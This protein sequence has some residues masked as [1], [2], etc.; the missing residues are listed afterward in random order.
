MSHVTL[1]R[2]HILDAAG[3]CVDDVQHALHHVVQRVLNQRADGRGTQM[4]WP[5]EQVGMVKAYQRLCIVVG[6]NPDI[7]CFLIKQVGP[8]DDVIEVLDLALQ[9]YHS[10]MLR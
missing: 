6:D 2:F 8:D 5:S 10:G 7:F 4:V 9:P 1:G 3:A